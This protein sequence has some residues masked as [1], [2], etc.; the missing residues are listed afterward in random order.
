M[1]GRKWTYI[2]RYK[3]GGILT[4]AGVVERG[5]MRWKIENEG[6]DTQRGQGYHLK[7]QFRKN[8]QAMK[9][10]YYLI[11]IGH[12]IAQMMEAWEKIWY[13]IRQSWE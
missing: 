4:I 9:N 11:Q 12:M 3:E 6:V 5:R 7:H 8:Y 1:R 10:H 2:L 13:G